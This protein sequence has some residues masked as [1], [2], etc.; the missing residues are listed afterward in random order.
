MP[1]RRRKHISNE[2]EDVPTH[3]YRRP[4]GCCDALFIPRDRE[5]NPWITC[6]FPKDNPTIAARSILYFLTEIV[7]RRSNSLVYLAAARRF[8]LLAL[9]LLGMRIPLD[10]IG[11]LTTL[12]LAQTMISRG[13]TAAAARKIDVRDLAMVDTG[14]YR[15]TCLD[16]AL[17]RIDAEEARLPIPLD[18][19]VTTVVMGAC[20]GCMAH[21]VSDNPDRAESLVMRITLLPC[22]LSPSH[23]TKSL[24]NPRCDVLAAIA[25][26]MIGTKTYAH[27]LAGQ[28]VDIGILLIDVQQVRGGRY[29]CL[30]ALL[31]RE[32]DLHTRTQTSI[33]RDALAVATGMYKPVR[34]RPY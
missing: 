33:V 18:I 31:S 13:Y 19:L 1:P 25:R 20:T 15:N 34:V 30:S 22:P 29:P 9:R 26:T 4:N 14:I 8:F 7:D 16:I 23:H 3:E 28:M 17:G 6:T 12:E 21:E 27:E 32:L 5:L 24:R 2:A 10:E 11:D